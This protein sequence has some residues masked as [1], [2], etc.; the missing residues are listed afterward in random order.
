ME[1]GRGV[2]W[3]TDNN[4]R[5]GEKGEEETPPPPPAT[6]HLIASNPRFSNASPQV[7]WHSSYT[8]QGNTHESP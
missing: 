8:L 1:G 5:G 2:G 3:C 6:R 7:Q 4:E